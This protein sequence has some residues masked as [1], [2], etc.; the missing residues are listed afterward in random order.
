MAAA[1]AL[2]P[3]WFPA[4][5]A[6]AHLGCA[7]RLAFR[8]LPVLIF[9]N[10]GHSA[11]FPEF[12]GTHVGIKSFQG[13]INLLRNPGSGIPEAFYATCNKHSACGLKNNTKIRCQRWHSACCCF[14]APP[15]AA[16]PCCH[17]CCHC[18]LFPSPSSSPL[19]SPSP[20]P[21]P[22]P[23][24]SPPFLLLP[25]LVDCCF[26]CCCRHRLLR[27]HSRHYRFFCC[28]I[29]LIVV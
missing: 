10:S 28:R 8:F 26:D 29:K 23:S 11:E 9:R 7:F 20:P 21:S 27:R 18:S 13:K 16:T 14:R 19:T 15:Q 5:G 24:P 2:R 22:S 1:V 12:R 25:R 3:P 4:P 17:H 6:T